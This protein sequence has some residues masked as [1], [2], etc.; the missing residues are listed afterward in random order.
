LRKA[1]LK[2]CNKPAMTVLNVER[3]AKAEVRQVEEQAKNPLIEESH[4]L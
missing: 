3:K 1:F 2:K 4:I